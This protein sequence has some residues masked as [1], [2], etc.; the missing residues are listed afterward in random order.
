MTSVETY[1][2]NG[3]VDVS[4]FLFG[5]FRKL[6]LFFVLYFFFLLQTTIDTSM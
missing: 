2:S 6:L 3:C 1:L 5:G 4:G